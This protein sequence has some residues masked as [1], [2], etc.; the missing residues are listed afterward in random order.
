MKLRDF[1][2]VEKIESHDIKLF[3][4]RIEEIYQ[5]ELKGGKQNNIN[6]AEYLMEVKNGNPNGF[7]ANTLYWDGVNRNNSF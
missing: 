3:Y 4:E 1:L 7:L 6:A 2:R 5:K